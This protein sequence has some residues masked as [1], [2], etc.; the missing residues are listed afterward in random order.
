MYPSGRPRSAFG[1]ITDVS[2]PIS[3]YGGVP[4]ETKVIL[5]QTP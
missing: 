2:R 4:W 1:L 5:L 3:M